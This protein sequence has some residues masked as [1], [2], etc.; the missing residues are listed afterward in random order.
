MNTAI[1]IGFIRV[2]EG[3]L[4]KYLQGSIFIRL[5]LAV[6]TVIESSPRQLCQCQ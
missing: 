6:Q 2:M 5:I 1:A 3:L 4:D